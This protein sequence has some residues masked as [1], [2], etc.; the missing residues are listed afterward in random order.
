MYIHTF[1]SQ[2]S[3]APCILRKMKRNRKSTAVAVLF[4]YSAN[5]LLKIC[6][7]N[8][9]VKGKLAL[10]DIWNYKK[11]VQEGWFL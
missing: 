9:F 7:R 5:F 10:A 2:A 1:W 11:P 6:F 4:L 8:V 3:L